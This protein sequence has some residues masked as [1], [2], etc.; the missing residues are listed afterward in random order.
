MSKKKN[1]RTFSLDTFHSENTKTGKSL[2]VTAVVM[3]DGDYLVLDLSPGVGNSVYRVSKVAV[4]VGPVQEEMTALD[5]KTLEIRHVTLDPK[6]TVVQMTKGAAE[7]FL[8]RSTRPIPPRARG[9]R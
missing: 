2:A 4:K 1:V 3:E 6:A 8:D 7:V 9:H 5:G